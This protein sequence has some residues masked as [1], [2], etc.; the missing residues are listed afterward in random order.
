MANW[1]NPPSSITTSVNVTHRVRSAY[2]PT[3]SHPVSDDPATNAIVA[4]SGN[5]FVS[6]INEGPDEVLV[7]LNGTAS[8]T[9]YNLIIPAGYNDSK[10][11]LADGENLSLI[12]AAG[13]T[14][15]VRTAIAQETEI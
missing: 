12:C 3:T 9:D 7:K 2:G 13:K 1:I 10:F 8:I 5:R 15:T 11:E 14:A 4:A 6:F